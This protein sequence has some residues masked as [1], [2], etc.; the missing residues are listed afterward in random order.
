M[1]TGA[2][3][4][5]VH[6]LPVLAALRRHFPAARLG[7]VVE[8]KFAPL[9]A[10]L[11]A[12]DETIVIRLRAWRQ[13]R[14]RP[15]TL[16]E[17]FAFSAALRRF[18]PDLVL[19]LMGSHRSGMIAAGSGC[20]RRVGPQRPD[21]W[22][23]SSAF[24][25]TEPTPLKGVHSVDRSLSLL[26]ALGLPPEPAD[27]IG[28]QL[29]PQAPPAPGD[30]L[31]IHPGAAWGDKVYPPRLWADVARRLRARTGLSVR[32]AIAPEEEHLPA[33]IEAAAAGA[34]HAVP[35][36]DL[37]AL[38]SLLRGARLVLGGDTGPLHLAHALGTP[39]L[40]LHGPTDPARSGPYGAPESFLVKRL[41]CSFCYQRFAEPKACL[42][43]LS[44]ARVA[45]RAA[46]LLAAGRPSWTAPGA[47][48]SAW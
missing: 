46:E 4:D 11:R 44:P 40:M 29:F 17:L 28:G 34:A 31:L 2:L 15:R 25:I 22:Q 16:R 26:D 1:R 23:P 39:V 7:W 18:A 30:Y 8:A 38:A 3:G 12:L 45:D 6:A 21:R 48:A 42:L 33:A 14:F 41:P 9:F 43:E 35:A 24:W 37:P 10:G 32:V 20:R 27:F 19:D 5:L 47:L 36:P 13:R